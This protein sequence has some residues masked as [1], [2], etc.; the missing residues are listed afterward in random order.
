MG[1]KKQIIYFGLC[2][3]ARQTRNL[4][5]SEQFATVATIEAEHDISQSTSK[6]TMKRDS[7]SN[8]KIN[9]W[10]ENIYEIEKCRQPSAW[11]KMKATVDNHGPEKFAKQIKAKLGRLKDEYKQIK[12]SNSR[13]AAAPQSSPYY[14]DFNELLGERDIVSFKQVKEVGCSKNTNLPTSPKGKV[15]IFGKKVSTSLGIL[16]ALKCS[17]MWLLQKALRI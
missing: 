5:P 1:R 12:D 2:G 8:N 11:V 3:S 6:K 17:S 4:E 16:V 9:A 13:T 10:E 7:W 15:H 14:N